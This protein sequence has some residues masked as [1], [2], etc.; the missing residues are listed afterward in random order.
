MTPEVVLYRYLQLVNAEDVSLK[1]FVE[2]VGMDADLLARWLR[3]LACPASPRALH[4]GIEALEPWTFVDLAQAQAWSVLPPGSS[5]RLGFDQWRSVYKSALLGEL[6]AEE[7][8]LPDPQATRWRLHLAM[9]GVNLECDPQL[10]DLI[11]Y[12]GTRPELLEDAPAEHKI[13]AVLDAAEVQETSAVAQLTER[14]L[15][16]PA[17]SFTT[18]SAE[19]GQRCDAQLQQAGLDNAG[20]GDR[21]EE[22]WDLQQVN[23]LAGLFLQGNSNANVQQAHTLAGKT[24]FETPPALFLLDTADNTL[25]APHQTSTQRLQNV[26]LNSAS[27]KVAQALRELRQ[28][29]LVDS[30]DCA[31]ADRQVLRSL[32]AE[33]GLVVPLQV[34]GEGI[35]VLVFA[36]DDDVAEGQ[37]IHAYS[38]ALGRWLAASS[39]GG[40]SG[41]AQLSSFREQEEKRLRTLVHEINNPLSIVSNYLHI[42]ELRLQHEPDATE[43]LSIIGRE[44]RR[45][46][47]LLQQ[48]REVPRGIEVDEPKAQV[49]LAEFEVNHLVEQIHQIHLGYAAEHEVDLRLALQPGTFLLRSDEQRV[50]QVIN[51]LLKNAIEAGDAA[52]W[53]RISTQGGVYRQGQRGVE[54]MVADDGPGIS[55]AVLD[56]LYEPKQSTKGGD[57]SGLGLH[58]V[59]QLVN[60]I[61]AYVD[62]RTAAGQGTEF[63]LFLPLNPNN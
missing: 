35:G 32:D 26:S 27:S 62:L 23:L 9:S 39:S 54:I 13:L 15:D 10:M 31:V 56:R 17:F 21:T 11:E 42:L 25:V 3:L 55:S 38:S 14:L 8:G 22:L 29:E 40:E 12:R 1:Q 52:S 33:E 20:N 51:N 50:T 7:L 45:A 5:M 2:L 18:L 48:V 46:A 49:T 41:T 53:V 28:L 59:H 43:Q 57:H 60:D 4:R 34:R 44:L 63:T 47:D 6:L 19:A 61:G 58:I 24:L 37:L 36:V 30:S 16:I